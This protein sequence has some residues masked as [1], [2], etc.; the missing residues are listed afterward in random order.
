M[1]VP[2]LQ[3][4]HRL[5]RQYSRPVVAAVARQVSPLRR[6]DFGAVPH[7]G[8]AGRT[9]LARRLSLVWRLAARAGGRPVR[10]HPA[11]GRPPPTPALPDPP[12]IPRRR[13][14]S[15]PASV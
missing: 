13:S 8:G 3:T 15:P 14:Y 7:R 12:P 5:A 1:D 9:H 6:A 11:G 2:A 10:H 4:T